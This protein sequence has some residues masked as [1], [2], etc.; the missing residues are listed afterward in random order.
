MLGGAVGD[1]L[2]DERAHGDDGAQLGG[3]TLAVPDL[4]KEDVVVEVGKLAQ[5]VV[6]RGLLDVC[7]SDFFLDAICLARSAH[8]SLRVPEGRLGPPEAYRLQLATEDGEEAG[9]ATNGLR[10]SGLPQGWQCHKNRAGCPKADTQV[11]ISG[12]LARK[13]DLGIGRRIPRSVFAAP[14][15]VPF[16]PEI[17][18]AVVWGMC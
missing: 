8:F 14:K 9:V 4:A 2:A 15:G 17:T 6:A 7:Y 10:R 3:E 18:C 5:G 11:G 13:A 16:S 1:V 12:H